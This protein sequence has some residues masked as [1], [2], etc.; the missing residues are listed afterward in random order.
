[1]PNVRCAPALVPEVRKFCLFDT[2]ACFQC[3]S[4]TVICNLT[5]GSA[6]FPRKIV[7]YPLLGLR[8]PLH[9]SLE[10]W[11]CYYC[12]DCS[13]TCPRETEPG[14]AMMTLRRFLTAQYDWTGLAGK[15]YKSN[16]WKIGS[17]LFVAVLVLLLALFYHLKIVGLDL[18]ELV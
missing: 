14:E 12:G 4:C 15:I 16:R 11:L 18:P 5:N 9:S 17:L 8:Q 13:T 10:P 2:N 1:M 3:G 6:S 7:R